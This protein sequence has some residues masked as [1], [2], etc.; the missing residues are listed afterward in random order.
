[1]AIIL[2]RISWY[3][4]LNGWLLTKKRC[5]FTDS[6]GNQPWVKFK[7][8]GWSPEFERT[9]VSIAVLCESV[10]KTIIE[11]VGKCET[12]IHTDC[13]LAKG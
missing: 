5:K 8:L 6:V 13:G 11:G 1:V 10:E 9:V 12:A 4:V 7:L 3:F 2:R